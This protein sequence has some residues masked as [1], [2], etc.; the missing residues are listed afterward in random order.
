MQYTW[1]AA[2]WKCEIFQNESQK[3]IRSNSMISGIF[4]KTR[5][6]FDHSNC[7]QRIHGKESNHNQKNCNQKHSKIY[8]N[9]KNSR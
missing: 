3:A 6:Y 4:N 2:L 7:K 5:G 1:R 8:D 9:K